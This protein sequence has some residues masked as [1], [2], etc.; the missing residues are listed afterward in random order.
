MVRRQC[1]NLS[2]SRF[3][4]VFRK[5]PAHVR[6]LQ[7]RTSN[8]HFPYFC[9]PKLPA[10]KFIFPILAIFIQTLATAQSLEDLDK[11]AGFKEFRI[12]DSLS[13]YQEKI[14]YMKTLDNADTQ[15]YLVKNQVSVKSYTGEVELE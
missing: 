6:W 9:S 7:P 1:A 12:G 2:S 4:S 10:M 14:K 11:K 8:F 3:L 13:V 15:L 5:I